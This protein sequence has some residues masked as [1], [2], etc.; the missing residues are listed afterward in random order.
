MWNL[1]NQLH[2]QEENVIKVYVKQKYF[3]LNYIK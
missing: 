3:L 2:K 1:G